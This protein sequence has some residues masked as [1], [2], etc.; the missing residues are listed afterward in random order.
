MTV[1]FFNHYPIIA[2]PDP[3]SGPASS[4]VARKSYR[5]SMQPYMMIPRLGEILLKR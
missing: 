2:D 4:R 1:T 3:L 5:L